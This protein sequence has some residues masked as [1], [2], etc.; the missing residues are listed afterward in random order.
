MKA[1]EKQSKGVASGVVALV[2]LVLGFQLAVFVIKVVERPSRQAEPGMTATTNNTTDTTD[3]T[4]ASEAAGGVRRSDLFSGARRTPEQRSERNVKTER[5]SERGYE[6]FPFDPNTVSLADLQRLG[7]TLR[8]A[9]TIDHYRSK[10]GRFRTKD[11]FRKMYVVTDTLFARL[12]PFIK[13]PKVELNAADSA[14]LVTLR[15]I[16]PY[17]ARKILDYRERLGGFLNKAQ[18][19]EIEGFDEERLAGF[20]D[21]VEIDTTRCSRLDLWHTTDSILAR[22]PYLGEK[23]ARSITRYKK[24]YDTTRWTLADLEKEH[25]LPKE[26]IEKLK[27]YIEIQ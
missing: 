19:L 24:L 2:F 16:G 18:L 3:A 26:N 6:T 20:F 22:H 14:A 9:E 5:R 12:E 21:D 23:G 13:I 17:Y 8:Q 15:G 4:V 27:K 11:D 25:A 1:G 10:G 7:L